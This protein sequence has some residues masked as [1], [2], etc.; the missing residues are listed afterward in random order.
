[1]KKGFTIIELIIYL[2]L[3]SLLLGILSNI[4]SATLNVKLGSEATSSVQQDGRF[5]VARL[6]YDIGRVDSETGDS[7]VVPS[8]TSINTPNNTLQLNIGGVTYTFTQNSGNLTLNGYP[9]NGENT[10]VSN[11]QFLRLGGVETG[12]LRDS[13]QFSFTLSSKTLLNNQ[14]GESRT[15]T[16]TAL[17][18]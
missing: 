17:P 9:L 12:G 4:F 15:F 2:G 8:P 11:L 7:I 13:I 16:S 18:R 6:A 3:F 5:M 14:P 1:M 10:T